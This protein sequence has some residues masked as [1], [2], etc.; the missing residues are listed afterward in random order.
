MSNVK[1]RNFFHPTP[2]ASVASRSLLHRINCGVMGSEGRPSQQADVS[3]V[4]LTHCRAT[5][6]SANRSIHSPQCQ[7]HRQSPGVNGRNQRTGQADE[8]RPQNADDHEPWG[9]GQGECQL[10]LG[11]R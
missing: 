8:Q 11:T 5:I 10:G 1:S 7:G 9:H 6:G 2:N 3:V 4:G